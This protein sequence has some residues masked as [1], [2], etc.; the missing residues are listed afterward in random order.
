MNIL[1]IFSFQTSLNTW[2]ENG[3]LERELEIY[4]Y[5]NK[6]YGYKYIFITYDRETVK[7]ENK[8]DFIKVINIY[9][10]IKYSNLKVMRIIKTIFFPVLLRDSMKSID[11]IQ[12]NQLNGVW[13]SL[14]CKMI[15]KKPLFIRTGYDQYLFSQYMR[16][17][18]Y[19]R[20]IFF[21]LTSIG[22][23]L[24]DLYSVTSYSDYMFL[25]S[26]FKFHKNKLT[27]IPNWVDIKYIKRF[28]TRNNQK[29]LSVGRLDDQKNYSKIIKDFENTADYLQI[30]IY[31]D[32][33]QKIYLKNLATQLNVK[34]EFF[35]NINNEELKSKLGEYKYYITAANFEGNP[36][37]VLE[38]MGHGC[39]VIASK[40]KNHEEI[41]DN[42]LNGFLVNKN[43]NFYES[44]L[45]IIKNDNLETISKNS[46]NKIKNSNSLEVIGNKYYEKINELK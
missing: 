27:L 21:V 22:L 24:A 19:K 25:K 1:L 39:I 31:G 43:D 46:I 45:K 36:K 15:Y 13:V 40:I 9:S 2:I 34:V 11:M 18:F 17:K 28:S 12:Q 10:K 35:G 7:L 41:I 32:G 16:K 33:P 5:L 6:K 8:F 37:S 38:A 14:V 23:K 26:K 4:E 20:A 29:I 42:G 44:Y 30:D 3:S